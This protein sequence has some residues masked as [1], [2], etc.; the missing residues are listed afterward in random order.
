MAK[1]AVTTKADSRAVQEDTR[2]P[3]LK[4][5]MEEAEKAHRANVEKLVGN[6]RKG[7]E[8]VQPRFFVLKA[9]DLTYLVDSGDRIDDDK[10]DEVRKADPQVVVFDRHN[11]YYG[12]G[13]PLGLTRINR[14]NHPVVG[15][16]DQGDMQK[17]GKLQSFPS[18]DRLSGSGVDPTGKNLVVLINR[19]VENR[20]RTEPM[21]PKMLHVHVSDDIE[22]AAYVDFGRISG[23]RL[24]ML[25]ETRRVDGLLGRVMDGRINRPSPKTAPASG[26]QVKQPAKPIVYEENVADALTELEKLAERVRKESKRARI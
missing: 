20:G 2:P 7:F 4:S 19:D 18:G 1:G 14:E 8:G 23:Q 3:E 5:F 22:T 21:D 17:I 13:V 9:G 25:D 11:M 12:R 16:I 10:S 24:D 26:L 15:L 6:A